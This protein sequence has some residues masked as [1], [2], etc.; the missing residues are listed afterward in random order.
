[1]RNS[2]L[3]SVCGDVLSA[4]DFVIGACVEC[5]AVEYELTNKWMEERMITHHEILVPDSLTTDQYGEMV[6]I[7]GYFDEENEWISYAKNNCCFNDFI[8]VG[9]Y[10]ET[11]IDNLEVEPEESVRVDEDC[12]MGDAVAYNETYKFFRCLHCGE[13]YPENE[14]KGAGMSHDYYNYN[15]IESEWDIAPNGR[16]ANGMPKKVN[17]EHD[18]LNPLYI[19]EHYLTS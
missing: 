11:D 12:Y 16:L 14:V 13:V 5:Q 3:C 17:D 4:K 7:S 18:R 6:K 15:S 9:W 2:N 19:V 8:E 1:M 10:E